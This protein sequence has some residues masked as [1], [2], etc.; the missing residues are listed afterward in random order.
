MKE[1]RLES[2]RVCRIWRTEID[3]RQAG[4]YDDFARTKSLRMFREQPGFVGVLFASREGHRVVIT[5]WHDLRSIEALR[6][7]VTYRATVD[8]I[9]QSGFLRGDQTVEVFSL[10]AVFDG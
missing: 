4:K 2:A 10:D 6:D 9:E 3:T 8:E 7:S 1:V 5:F